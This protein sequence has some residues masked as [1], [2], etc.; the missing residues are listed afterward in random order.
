MIGKQPAD[1]VEIVEHLAC[2]LEKNLAGGGQAHKFVGSFEQLHP[3]APF[4]GDNLLT[5]RGL[6]Q[7]ELLRCSSEAPGISDRPK[8]GQ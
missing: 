6:R 2:A 7:P 4:Q 5:Y 1:A 3:E 8:S